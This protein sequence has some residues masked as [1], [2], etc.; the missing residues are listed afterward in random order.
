MVRLQEDNRRICESQSLNRDRACLLDL[1]KAFP[2]IN[3]PLLWKILESYGFEDNFLG[4]LKD[5]HE[6]TSYKVKGN[7][8]V[9]SEWTPQRGLREG[10]PSSP[11]LFNIYHQITIRAAEKQSED[12][13]IRITYVPGN[14]CM[15]QRRDK[16]NAEA[17]HVP[18]IRLVG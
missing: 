13:G 18:Q 6:I 1:R 17:K 16:Q 2:R 15:T 12:K 7:K 4:R 3:R 9:S 10:C 5:L 8:E 11:I 14:T